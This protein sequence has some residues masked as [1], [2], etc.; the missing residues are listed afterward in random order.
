MIQ[1]P[2]N[3]PP[4][5]NIQDLKNI[6][7][8]FMRLRS[9]N[10]QPE[11]IE[12]FLADLSKLGADEKATSVLK[13]AFIDTIAAN[14]NDARSARTDKVLVGGLTAI[15]LVIFQAL[16]SF[17]PID[18]ATVIALIALGLSILAAGGY[19]FIRFIQEDHN[20]QDYDWKVIGIFPFISLLATAIGIPAAIWHVSWLAAIIFFVSSVIIG[21]FCV[22]YYASVAIRAE[23]K[24]RYEFTQSGHMD[25]N[26]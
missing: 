11:D 9:K 18:I 24:K 16:L 12:P 6:I 21:I 2:I 20:I 3:N 19:L 14:Q 4:R 10:A 25:A 15:D 13:E 22:F 7:G 5:R 8:H 26:S 17:N 23:A 1:E